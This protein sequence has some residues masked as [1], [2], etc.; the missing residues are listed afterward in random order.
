MAVNRQVHFV[1]QLLGRRGQ[2]VAISTFT[3]LK[4]DW[5][6]FYRPYNIVHCTEMHEVHLYG[7]KI[8]T[9]QTVANIKTRLESLT[10]GP[11]ECCLGAQA[12]C[13]KGG[14]GYHINN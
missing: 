13:R 6:C 1:L 12:F 5:K 9:T 7:L 14:K 2:F 8:P 10:E 3:G 11:T 4:S